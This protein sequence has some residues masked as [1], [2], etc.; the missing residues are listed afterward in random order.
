MGIFEFNP[1]IMYK[2][3]QHDLDHIQALLSLTSEKAQHYLSSLGETQTSN[4][5][6]V[7]IETSSLETEGK[8]LENTLE[9]FYRTH[10][11]HI[12]ASSGPK[13]WGFVTGGTTPAAIA[14]D[15]LSTV[16]DQNPQGLSGNGDLSARIEIE[17]IGWMK[18]LFGLPD[19]FNGGFVSGATMANFTCLAVGRQ[20]AGLQ[21][22]NDIARTGLQT[23]I[24]V[25]SAMPHSSTLK[26]LSML[27][28]GS[29]NIIPV[30]T[31]P[32]NREA[33][34]IEDLKA[35]IQEY[36][37]FPLLVVSSAGTVNTADFDDMEAIAALQKD[38]PF[39]WHIDAAF[40]G[41]AACSEKSKY[42]LKGWEQADSITVD[43]HKWMNVPYDSAIYL[44]HKKHSKLQ[45]ATFQ[46][47]NAPYLG[48]PESNF[49]YL[50]FGPENSR[51]LRALPAWFT[52]KAYGKKGYESIVENN[53]EHA[54][55]FAHLLEQ[56]SPFVLAAPVRLNIVCFTVKD[57]AE[58]KAFLD[59]VWLK[60]NQSGKLFLSPTVYNG[61]PCL[62]AAFV[63]WRTT[64]QDVTEGIE[65]LKKTLQQTSEFPE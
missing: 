45:M 40:G 5:T 62:R 34:D 64:E 14:A 22:G 33:M 39:F 51:R 57:Q 54:R 61:Q 63:N 19:A 16:F 55:L 28:I 47:S 43:C 50:N 6:P 58:P 7:K 36:Q 48:D 31:L 11:A 44:I 52:L 15:W 8:G 23:T 21:K 42:L 59:Q 17:T 60:L 10:G 37:E 18:E 49:S 2:A 26:S 4:T 25:L 12:V 27:G 29:S 41:F 3:L 38:F 1:F 53:L 30:K 32:G 46:N 20:W 65:E 56:T 35:C 13:Y 24:K 9:S